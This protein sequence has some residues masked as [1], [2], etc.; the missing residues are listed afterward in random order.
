MER[1]GAAI[2][3]GE[4]R[5][6][7]T[8]IPFF[9]RLMIMGAL[10]F[11]AN[12]PAVAQNAEVLQKLVAAKEAAAENKQKL[13]QYQWT[14][15][16][17]ITL[18][19]DAKPS[20]QKLCQ[21]GPDGQ[22][23]KTPIGPPPEEPSGGRLKRRIIEKKKEEM[24]EYMEEV[25][26]VLSMYV[27]PES[28]KM[29]QA[30]QSGNLSLNPAGTFVNLIFR[31]YAQ[32][33]DQMTLTFDTA[34]KKI[35]SL[36]VNTYMGDAKDAVT[37]QVQ[38]ASLPDGTSYPQQTV[39]NASAKQLVV[40]TT[41][42]NYQELGDQSAGTAPTGSAASNYPGQGV[43]ATAEE[44]QSLV[45]PIAL[46]PDALVAQI[47]TAATFPDQVAI[48]NYWLQ[49]NKTLT[50]SALATAVDKQTWDA[51]VKALTLFPSVLNNMAQNLSW[52]SQLGED[53][54]NQQADVMTAVQT[55]RAK[56]KEAGNLK[57]SSQVT[58][59]QKSPQVIVI[60]PTNPQVVYVPVYNPAVVYGY[61]YVVPA[62]TPPPS[63]V[64]VAGVIGFGAGIA[65]GAMM[66]DG[67]CGWGY[68]SWN[69]NWY[70]GAAVYHGGAYYG[71]NAWHGG[72]YGSSASAYG[73]YGSAHASAGYN[74][75]TGTYAR[76]ASTSTAYGTQKVGQAYNPYTGAY[77]ATHQGSNAYSNWGSST[78]SKNGQTVDTQHYSDA[79]GTVG[80]AESSNGNKYATANGNAYKNTGSGWQK[81]G[82]NSD[83]AHG[84]GSSSGSDYHSSGSSA[85]GGWGSHSGG[86]SGWGSRSSSAQGWGSRG[87]GGG[88]GGRGGGGWGGRR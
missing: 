28:Q 14:E 29:E 71:N 55:L 21:Y 60:Q 17:Q 20:S 48:A 54:H 65:V 33:G 49:Q 34:T 77:G 22:V 83:A 42:S 26:V 36:N 69:C 62:Y 84:W 5:A 18:K 64:V 66:S 31:N 88:W 58:V 32:P 45:A 73:A 41:N 27:P 4:T 10:A 68:S 30:Y 6:T 7:S 82:S 9:K 74:P 35:L 40:T 52:T 76:G 16:T 2:A 61:P 11:T 3:Y 8:L 15:T 63:T 19:G 24:Q 79:N 67:C 53:Y 81:A 23:Q 43:P 70:G 1:T 39:L 44:L 56:A 47:L 86:D 78:A 12:S 59:V 13:H 85:F 37:L 50:G 46:Y 72:Y 75:S 57:T 87:G 25:K 38:M 51:S 80:T